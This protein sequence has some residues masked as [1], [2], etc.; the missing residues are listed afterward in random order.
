MKNAERISRHFS[1]ARIA[2]A[3]IA[4]STKLIV[5]FHLINRGKR[6][7]KNGSFSFMI[8]HGG[9]LEKSIHAFSPP[10]SFI[11]N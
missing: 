3:Q 11:F 8:I 10:L 1:A 2:N 4:A 6:K 7:M 5:C 9:M